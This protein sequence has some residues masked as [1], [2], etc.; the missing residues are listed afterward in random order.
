MPNTDHYLVAA[1]VAFFPYR[2]SVKPSRVRRYDIQRLTSDRPLQQAYSAA[3]QNLFSSLGCLPD[4]VEE[5]WTLVTPEP[6]K[7]RVRT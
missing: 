1:E 4:D 2:N 3:V 7:Y 5:C 6:R